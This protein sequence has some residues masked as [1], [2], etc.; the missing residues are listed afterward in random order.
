M[1][2]LFINGPILKI[3]PIVVF[4][5]FCQNTRISLLALYVYFL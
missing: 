3:V 5:I 2:Y 4:L 1:N